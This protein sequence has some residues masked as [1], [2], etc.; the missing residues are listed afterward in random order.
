M[1]TLLKKWNC[2][3]HNILQSGDCV[4]GG[5]TQP[6][7]PWTCTR[8]KKISK[9]SQWKTK[10]RRIIINTNAK[11][12]KWRIS[13]NKKQY[14]VRTRISLEHEQMKTIASCYGT[15]I[16]CTWPILVGVELSDITIL[17][18]LVWYF[19]IEKNTHWQCY[20]NNL[21]RTAYLKFEEVSS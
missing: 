3:D 18:W 17:T 12:N 4:R 11:A 19:K 1:I 13:E 8:Q 10:W 21:Y 2:H 15:T 5:H 7:P 6:P 20:E 9:Y 16:L 14:C